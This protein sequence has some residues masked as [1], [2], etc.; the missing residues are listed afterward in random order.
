M[1]YLKANDLTQELC[2]ALREFQGSLR[3]EMSV[4][5][6]SMQ[7]LRQC[8]HMLLWLDEWE[9]LDPA[10]CWSECIRRDF[11]AMTGDR[12]AKYHA[13]LKHVRGNAPVRDRKSTRL[14]SSH[15]IISYAVFCLKKK[16]NY[17]SVSL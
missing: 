14:N 2:R 15:Q 8:L 7:S 4:S 9:P 11:R 5:Q 17:L 1:E 3:E 10:R 12:R 13:L 6:A 16:N